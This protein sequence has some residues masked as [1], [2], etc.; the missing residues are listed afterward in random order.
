M[1]WGWGTF[2]GNDEPGEVTAS[3]RPHGPS[4]TLT[5]RTILLV[6]SLFCNPCSAWWAQAG[7]STGLWVGLSVCVWGGGGVC[8]RMSVGGCAHLSW[9]AIIVNK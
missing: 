8:T 4:S 6:S 9:G 3:Q 7:F 5:Q 2:L 1:P